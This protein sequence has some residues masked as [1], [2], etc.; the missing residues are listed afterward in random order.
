MVGLGR[1]SLFEFGDLA[2][3]PRPLHEAMTR[4]LAA[5]YALLPSHGHWARIIA[6]SLEVQGVHTVIDLCSGAGGPVPYVQ[7]ELP[8]VRFQLT[9]LH[10]RENVEA[11]DALH[12]PA[13]RI[14]VRTMFAAFHH[15]D[16][17]AAKQILRGAA[18]SRQSLCIFEATSRTPAAIASSLLIPLL[19]LLLTPRVK[20][21]TV[22]QIVFTY[23]IPILPFVIAWDGFVSH[24]R[25]YTAGEM[26]AMANECPGDGYEWQALDLQVEGVPFRLPTLIGRPTR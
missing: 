3:F 25:T 23:V 6:E 5:T 20:G 8:G 17:P 13:D 15:F 11:L 22:G 19:V 21:L 12:V 10:P 4:Y 18:S 14:G 1:L 26:Q 7:K 24:C 16:P 9:D 2:W